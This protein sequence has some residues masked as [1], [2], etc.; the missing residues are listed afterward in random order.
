MQP[1]QP[2]RDNVI[3]YSVDLIQLFL[4]PSLSHFEFLSIGVS[5]WGGLA[6]STKKQRISERNNEIMIMTIIYESSTRITHTTT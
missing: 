5:S 1:K 4:D 3:T 2:A 6:D